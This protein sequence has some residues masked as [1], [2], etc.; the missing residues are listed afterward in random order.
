M[1]VEN[2]SNR[3]VNGRNGPVA[4]FLLDHPQMQD[5]VDISPDGMHASGRF[6]MLFLS[7]RIMLVKLRLLLWSPCTSAD[8]AI[9]ELLTRGPFS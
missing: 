1:Y 4:G 5:I 3:F 8:I 9:L 2:F 6:R 7:F